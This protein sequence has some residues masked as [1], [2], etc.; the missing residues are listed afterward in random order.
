MARYKNIPRVLASKNNYAEAMR[1]L[2]AVHNFSFASK[3]RNFTPQQKSS[4]TRQWA[5]YKYMLSLLE[6]KK[7]VTKKITPSQKRNLHDDDFI[8]TNKVI[9]MGTGDERTIKPKLKITGKGKK[10]KV[11]ASL[12]SRKEVFYPWSFTSTNRLFSDWA[13]D[14]V[15]KIK[16][17]GVMVALGSYLG[18]ATYSYQQALKYLKKEIKLAEEKY[19]LLG[20]KHPFTGIWFITYKF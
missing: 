1:E 10:T 2:R 5:K 19:N 4:I 16:P 13:Y 12:P 9:F 7:G 15:K 3:R 17:D 6:R 11:I 8:V 18:K 20:T 14:L